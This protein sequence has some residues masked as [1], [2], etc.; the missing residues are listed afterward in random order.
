VDADVRTTTQLRQ[1]RLAF[2]EKNVVESAKVTPTA[3][4][5]QDVDAT[6]RQVPEAK[7]VQSSTLTK[8]FRPDWNPEQ[9]AEEKMKVLEESK[10]V[11]ML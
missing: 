11:Q 1:K 3:N 6:K 2:F 8:D 10:L 4:V 9:L 7:I 5:V